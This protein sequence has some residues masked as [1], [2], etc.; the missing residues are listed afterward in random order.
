MTNPL[1]Q[2]ALAL[3]CLGAAH[4]ALATQPA[5]SR[6]VSLTSPVAGSAMAPVA[7]GKLI[8]LKAQPGEIEANKAL[9]FK[10]E[11]SGHCKLS[12]NSGDGNV[13]GFEGDLPFSGSYTYGTGAM[14]SFDAFKNYTATATPSGNCKSGA[15]ISTVV[16]VINPHPQSA[17]MPAP[18]AT[19]SS[20]L[21]VGMKPGKIEPGSGVPATIKSISLAAKAVTGAP[22]AA[23]SLKEGTPTY[24]TVNGTG[25]CKYRLSYVKKNEL[26]AQPMMVKSSSL[27][28]PFPMSLKMFDATTGGTYTWTASGIDGCTGSA[29]VTFEVL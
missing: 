13:S 14:S 8:A 7:A 20:A 24:L 4:A 28:S 1:N 19:V 18:Q 12:L 17:G 25:I 29:N 11:G 2:I 9:T 6:G 15:A 5:A 10:F 26:A 23:A 16:K 22:I 27:Q 3:L 21:K